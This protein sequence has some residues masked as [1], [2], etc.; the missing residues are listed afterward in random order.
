MTPLDKFAFLQEV[1][2][3]V[4]LRVLVLLERDNSSSSR[5]WLNYPICALLKVKSLAQVLKSSTLSQ[6]SKNFLLFVCTKQNI[7]VSWI[8]K[9]PWFADRKF[10]TQRAFTLGDCKEQWWFVVPNLTMYRTECVF[11]LGRWCHVFLTV[12]GDRDTTKLFSSLSIRYESSE[13]WINTL[14]A[15]TSIQNNSLGFYYWSRQSFWTQPL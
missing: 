9:W 15:W 8:A 5:S 7:G 3:T 12:T 13:C 11:G 6:S 4:K 1:Y 10:I 14:W 2:L